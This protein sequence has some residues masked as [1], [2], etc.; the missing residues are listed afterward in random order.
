MAL[1]EQRNPLIR[2]I[3]ATDLHIQ[4]LTSH[5][6]IHR[7][8]SKQFLL[9]LLVLYLSLLGFV[10]LFF[11]TKASKTTLMSTNDLKAHNNLFKS[12]IIHAIILRLQHSHFLLMW[13][14]L[15]LRRSQISFVARTVMNQIE[16][17]MREAT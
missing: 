2:S 12:L 7:R 15:S 11:N 16:I 8:K 14:K 1:Q 17:G 6:C 10:L 4:T 5:R 13:W 3:Y 9:L